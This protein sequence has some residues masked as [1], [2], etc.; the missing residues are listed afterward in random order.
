MFCNN[1]S[2]EADIDQIKSEPGENICKIYASHILSLCIE[3]LGKSS[4]CR[5]PS[6]ERPLLFYNSRS[7]LCMHAT[8]DRRHYYA[9]YY[10]IAI[11][12]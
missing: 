12:N 4:S 1:P 5:E 10:Y 6:A 8:K 3:I 2:T 7:I 11:D 9:H